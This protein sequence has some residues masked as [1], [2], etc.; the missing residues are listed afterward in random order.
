MYFEKSLVELGAK[1]NW[2]ATIVEL[3]ESR[4]KYEKA[5]IFKKSGVKWDELMRPGPKLA[6]GYWDRAP[7]GYWGRAQKD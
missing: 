3:S 2:S 5:S 4:I 1:L 7:K 6:K